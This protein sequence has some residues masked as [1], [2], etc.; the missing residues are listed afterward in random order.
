M[1]STSCPESLGRMLYSQYFVKSIKYFDIPRFIRENGKWWDER[2]IGA[3][4][5]SSGIDNGQISRVYALFL[6]L[7]YAVFK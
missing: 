3:E 5:R 6:L 4:W 7:L 1:K 2:R